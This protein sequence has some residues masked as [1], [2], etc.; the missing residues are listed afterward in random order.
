M[1][2]IHQ[3]MHFEPG[4]PPHNQWQQWQVL[5]SMPSQTQQL[6]QEVHQQHHHQHL[7]LRQQ[8][9]QPSLQ[10]SVQPWAYHLETHNQMYVTNPKYL[11][12]FKSQLLVTD[13]C[14]NKAKWHL[15]LA[16]I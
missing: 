15:I 7:H 2:Q 9:L 4:P 6:H 13:S 3:Q 12:M 16:D 5:Q 10:T 1:E 8:V 11:H 14:R